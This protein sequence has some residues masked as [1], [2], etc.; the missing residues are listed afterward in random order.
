MARR[1]VGATERP[2]DRPGVSGRVQLALC[3][4]LRPRD[5]HADTSL[6]RARLTVRK[7]SSNEALQERKSGGQSMPARVMGR[8]I[9]VV[10]SAQSRGDCGA[11]PKDTA[12]N[13]TAEQGNIPSVINEDVGTSPCRGAARMR[14]TIFFQVPPDSLLQNVIRLP[15][16]RRF[17]CS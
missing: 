1:W 14:R 8:C 4:H 17:H 16:R 10:E 5:V 15:S 7:R 2:G 13:R 11:K 9:E 12:I 6:S 3:S